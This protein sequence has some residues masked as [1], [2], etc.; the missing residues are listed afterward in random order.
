MKIRK[1]I[2]CQFTIW[3]AFT[4]TILVMNIGISQRMVYLIIDQM[5]FQLPMQS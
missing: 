2:T 5:H 3:L 4:F 1:V